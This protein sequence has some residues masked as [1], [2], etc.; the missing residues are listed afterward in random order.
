M[1]SHRFAPLGREPIEAPL[2]FIAPVADRATLTVQLRFDV[3]N[4]QGLLKPNEYVDVRLEEGASSIL[5][6]PVTAPIL[7]EGI[8]GVF[9]KRNASYSFVPVTLGQESDGWIEVLTGLNPGDA[10]VS[11]GVFDLKNALLKHS[12]EGA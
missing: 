10:V 4:Q 5:A 9:V 6:I 11:E 7:V 2:A 12:I 1:T 3:D 8:R